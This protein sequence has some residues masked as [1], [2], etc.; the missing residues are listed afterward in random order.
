[1][2]LDI[3]IDVTYHLPSQG[4]LLDLKGLELNAEIETGNGSHSAAHHQGVSGS[5]PQEWNRR[6]GSF[7]SDGG[8]GPHSRRLLSALRFQGSTYRRSVRR[9]GKVFG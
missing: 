8:G 2:S 3:Y 9:C 5:I 7:R 6:D 4:R 1:M